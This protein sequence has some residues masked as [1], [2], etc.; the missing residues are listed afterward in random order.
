MLKVLLKNIQLDDDNTD[1]HLQHPEGELEEDDGALVEEEVPHPQQ[2]LHVDDAGEG[3][4]EPVQTDER[5]L[6]NTSNRNNSSLHT[7]QRLH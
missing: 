4:Q 5:Q 3:R 2:H 6:C 1:F 7:F